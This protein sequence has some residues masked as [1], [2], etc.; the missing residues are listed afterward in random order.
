MKRIASLVALLLLIGSA[1]A[2]EKISPK[3]QALVDVLQKVLPEYLQQA[4]ANEKALQPFLNSQDVAVAADSVLLQ[5]MSIRSMPKII[6]EQ[7]EYLV[8]HL[9]PKNLERWKEA[10]AY[11][12]DHAKAGTDAFAGMVSGVRPFRSRIDGQILLYKFSLPKD[13]DSTKKYPLRIDLHAGAGFMWLGYW[14]IG[15]P[16][17]DPRTASDDDAIHISPAGRQHVGMGEVAIL[18][19]IA[20]VKKHYSVDDDRLVIGGASWGGTGGFHFATLLPDHFA[21]AH[22]LTGG[23]NYAVPVGNG[24]FDAYLLGDNLCNL[25]FLIWD[26]PGDGHFKANHAFADG[27]RERAAKYPGF[28]PHLE[29]TDPKGGHGIIDRKLLDEGKAWMSKQVRNRYPRSVIYK[30]HCLRYD[31][32]YWARIDTTTD[33][34]VPSRIEAQMTDDGGCRVA[35]E[36]VERFHL[37]LTPQLTG[38]TA[39]IDVRINDDRLKVPAGKKTFFAKTAG[40]WGVAAE[41]YPP[42]LIKKHGLSGPIQDVFMERPV[43]M[44]Y[45]TAEDKTPAATQRMLDDIVTRLLGSGDG[46]G[47][48]HNGFERKADSAVTEKDIADKNL[49]V[50]GTPK[51]NRFLM[52]MADKLPATFLDDGVKIAGKEYRGPDVGLVMIYPNPLNPERYVLL[53]PEVYWGTKTW[54]YPDYL[55]LRAP[56][57]G[58]KMGAILAKGNFDARWQIAKP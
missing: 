35:A 37:D 57:Q 49:I 24:R 40:K 45:G 50:V 9:G 4:D 7:P 30:S 12:L 41:R 46:S 53:L 32:A 16:S 6:A 18:E 15:Q 38:E 1:P 34:N 28:Y 26:T 39:D 21:A 55:V 31:G 23:G 25:P 3:A 52:K 17:N 8:Y 11:F 19:A 22:S 13:Y 58:S 29:L 33:A 2:Q 47:F 51:Q 27:L 44:V 20:D 42:G 48:L 43:L 54:D 36:N 10:A 56:Q 5:I 14:V